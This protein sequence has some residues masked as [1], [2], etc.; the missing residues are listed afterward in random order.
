MK[1]KPNFVCL[2]IMEK[3]ESSKRQKVAN[4]ELFETTEAIDDFNKEKV[5]QTLK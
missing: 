1:L 4:K 5:R 2:S 3:L